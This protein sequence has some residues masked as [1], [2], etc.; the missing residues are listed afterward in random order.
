MT[1]GDSGMTKDGKLKNFM[2]ALS[3]LCIVPFGVILI[4]SFLSD[5]KFSLFQYG[6]ALLQSPDFMRAFWNSV[7]YTAVIL[8][9]NIPVSIAS[10]Y[11]FAFFRA[12]GK[13]LLLG[14]YILIMV[15][16]FQAMTVPQYITLEWLGILDTPW[17]VI[18]PNI[19]FT[20]GTFLMT[21]YMQSVDKEIMEAGRIDGL[22]T[23]GLLVKII[24][25][26]CRPGFFTLLVLTFINYWSMV[27]QPLLFLKNENLFPLS[28]V[29]T[30]GGAMSDIKFAGGVIFAVLPFLIYTYCYDDLAGGISLTVFDSKNINLTESRVSAGSKKIIS[31]I[32]AGFLIFMT[33]CA[34]FTQKTAYIMAA[35]VFAVDSEYRTIGG[36]NYSCTLPRECMSAAGGGSVFVIKEKDGKAVVTREPVD[37][38]ASGDGYIAL[39]RN[40]ENVVLYTS[41]ALEEGLEVKVIK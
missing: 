7:I 32:L 11:F 13:G 37:I 9:F 22:G 17:A 26:I 31:K 8:L 10:A 23:F 19:F 16:P 34:L 6:S 20:I 2:Y 18:L 35:E 33:V 14:L 30:T 25:P 40:M 21:Q 15:M 27:E 41:R 5:G 3:V 36:E 12:K 1:E 4:Y 24:I 28:M 29:L 38:I 39:K